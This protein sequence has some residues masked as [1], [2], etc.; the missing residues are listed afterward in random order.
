[1]FYVFQRL[2]SIYPYYMTMNNDNLQMPGYN[3]YR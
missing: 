3:V 2:L 1:M